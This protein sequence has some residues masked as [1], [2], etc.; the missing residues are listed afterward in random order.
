MKA[1]VYRKYGPSEVLGIETLP[2]PS[3]KSDQVL[4]R[5]HATT[6]NRTDCGMRNANY[7]VSRLF[8]GLTKPK[9][10]V[11][12]SE[13][14]GEVVGIGSDVKNFKLAIRSLASKTYGLALTQNI[15]RLR[16]MAL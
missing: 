10:I 4:V 1:A 15:W 11:A 16:R 6:M 14:A 12:G 8:T 13:F 5:V 2:K 9:H 7:V 3:I